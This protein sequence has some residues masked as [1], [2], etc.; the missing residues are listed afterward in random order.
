MRSRL[1]MIGRTLDLELER[2]S[3]LGLPRARSRDPMHAGKR[4]DF[5]AVRFC[6]FKMLSISILI[7]LKDKAEWYSKQSSAQ[8]RRSPRRNWLTVDL[9]VLLR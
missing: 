7:V 2:R 1:G 3:G 8:D 5:V 4:D 9:E 6:G